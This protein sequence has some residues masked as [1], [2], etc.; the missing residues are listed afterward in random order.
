MKKAVADCV[1]IKDE[2]QAALAREYSGLSDEQA[3]RKLHSKLAASHDPIARLWR[4]APARRPARAKTSH[5][6]RKSA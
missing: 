2:I 5:R 1:R 4:S 6:R 3:A